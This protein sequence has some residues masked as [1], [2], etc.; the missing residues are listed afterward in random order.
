MQYVGGFDAQSEQ[1]ALSCGC[2]V[3][4]GTKCQ[5]IDRGGNVYGTA[6]AEGQSGGGG[7]R[8]WGGGGGCDVAFHWFVLVL[9]K[10]RD[11]ASRCV[12]LK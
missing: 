11:A 9:S 3:T 2:C 4:A 5:C 12:V 10:L 7:E 8:G 1:S 6:G